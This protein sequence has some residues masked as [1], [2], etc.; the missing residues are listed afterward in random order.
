MMVCGGGKQGGKFKQHLAVRDVVSEVR[1]Q[2]LKGEGGVA[3]SLKVGRDMYVCVR[4]SMCI[5]VW[6]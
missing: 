1:Q 6:H 5:Y 4:V 2:P 3:G